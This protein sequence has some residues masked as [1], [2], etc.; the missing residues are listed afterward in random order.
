MSKEISISVKDVSKKYHL[1]DANYLIIKE[2][3]HPFKKSFHTDFWALKNVSFDIKKGETIGILGP[4]GSGKSSLLKIICSILQ[5]SS[6]RISINGRISGILELGAGFNP[7][8]TGRDNAILNC[9]ILGMSSKEIDARLPEIIKFADIGDYFDRPVKFYSSGM[10][11]RLAFSIAIHVDPDILII[12]EAL[13]VG[14]VR[15]QNK[16][17]QKFSNFKAAGK[18]ILFVTHNPDMVAKHCNRVLV[19]ERGNLVYDGETAEGIDKYIRIS[20]SDYVPDNEITVDTQINSEIGIVNHEEMGL[21][22]DV[23]KQLYREPEKEYFKTRQTYNPNE[24][25]YGNGRAEIIDFFL[26]NEDSIDVE[27]LP[28][29]AQVDLY[30]RVHYVEQSNF[31]PVIGFSVKSL[32]GIE[33]F[34]T[35][36]FIMKVAVQPAKKNDCLWYRFQFPVIFPA[37][38]YFLD[39][40]VAHDDGT[41]GGQPLDVRRFV[42][43][44]VV[45]P[46]RSAFMGLCYLDENF[47]ELGDLRCSPSSN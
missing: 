4:N 8:F 27:S 3:L 19:F 47:S 31:R 41:I 29:K 6:G 43:H 7:D 16:C 26:V 44:F 20:F 1:Y 2:V 37:G 25:H 35:N 33:L 9:S 34:G 18:T 14:D 40:G 15:F 38:D 11:V 17:F 21:S 13:A 23:L 42:C 32:D 12:D 28:F 30:I 39:L 36:T 10:F 24:T 46:G 22:K 45:K 5:P